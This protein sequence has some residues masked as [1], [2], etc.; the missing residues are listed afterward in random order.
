M[1]SERMENILYEGNVLWATDNEI[2]AMDFSERFLARQFSFVP[3]LSR[4]RGVICLTDKS[5]LIEGDEDLVIPLNHINQ[6]YLGFDD[7]YSV[8]SVKNFGLFWQPIRVNYGND[9]VVYLIVDYNFFG[10]SNKQ[11]FGMLTELFTE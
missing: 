9:L 8:A 11:F 6:L 4:H 1:L 10:S 3:P 2:T 5:I 7:V